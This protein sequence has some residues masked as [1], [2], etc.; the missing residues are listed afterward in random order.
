VPHSI[1][2]SSTSEGELPSRIAD[3]VKKNPINLISVSD[4]PRARERVDE[5][6]FSS[7]HIT[8]TNQAIAASQHPSI[9]ASIN[10]H[11]RVCS[12]QGFGDIININPI[13]LISASDSPRALERV[14]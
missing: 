14:D 7:D 3:N 12:L 8:S 4:S 11:L 1:L 10:Q 9:L 2:P 5:F 13:N 6:Q